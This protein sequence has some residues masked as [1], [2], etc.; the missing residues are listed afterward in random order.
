MNRIVAATLNL[1]PLPAVIAGQTVLLAGLG[2]S[3]DRDVWPSDNPVALVPLFTLAFGWPTLVLFTAAPGNFRRTAACAGG[4]VL[5]AVLLAAYVGWQ[6]T[7]VRQFSV[8]S[9]YTIHVATQLAA[10]FIAL[11]FMQQFVKRERV[12]YVALFA[13]AWRNLLVALL[14]LAL[15]GG[16]AILLALWAALFSIL[17]ID[18]LAETFVEPWF[19]L[20]TVGI[21]FGVG[22]ILFRRRDGLLDGIVGLMESLA[23][24]LLPVVLTIIAVFLVT[25][26]FVTVGALWDTGLGSRILIALGAIAVL[27]ICIAYRPDADLRYPGPVQAAVTVIVAVLPVLS[28]LALVGILIRV[29]QYGW[30]VSRCW[31]VTFAAILFL[32]SLGYVWGVIR[33]LAEWPRVTAPVNV[34]VA[35]MVLAVLILQN[36]P[37]LD[38][39]AISAK[40]QLA[41]V[42]SGEI[43][44]AQFDFL[45]ARRELARPGHLVAGGLVAGLGFDPRDEHD[46]DRSVSLV[47]EGEMEAFRSSGV[48]RRRSPD[49]VPDRDFWA[50]VN[51]RPEP[52]DVPDG[53]REAIDREAYMAYRVEQPVLVRTELDGDSERP[54]FLLLGMH[55]SEFPGVGVI[56]PHVSF[57]PLAYVIVDPGDGWEFVMLFPGEGHEPSEDAET[58][59]EVL[60]SAPI[61][62]VR[63][64]YDH[65]KIGDTVY[66]M[67]APAE[68]QSSSSG[69]SP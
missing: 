38:F 23:R 64:R 6:A 30:T 22:T 61:I 14:S 21:A 24:Y 44:A 56:P 34:S 51:F 29:S 60:R 63:P 57:R 66:A 39:R 27:L 53:V 9:L 20:P 40:S 31:A 25:L 10:G 28:A 52:F 47:P 5:V 8:G 68:A 16:V 3:L 58:V 15:L 59:L 46:A 19:I 42:E 55:R 69:N 49:D 36:T 67:S 4:C 35:C 41:R 18:A 26:P 50:E 12:R 13:N 11:A 45:Y 7:P 54:E 62:P 43:E 17:G 65:V 37:L 33:H 32:F 48:I 2:V 1:G